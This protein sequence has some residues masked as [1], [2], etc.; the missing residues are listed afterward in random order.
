MNLQQPNGIIKVEEHSLADL[1][2]SVQELVLKGYKVDLSSNDNYPYC[3][4]GYYSCGMV[5]V[6]DVKSVNTP[7]KVDVVE[8]E[9]AVDGTD[10]KTEVKRG[11]KPKGE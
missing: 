5:K 9:V 2:S 10:V 1:L 7:V 3:Y 6:E 8:S 11:R 4:V